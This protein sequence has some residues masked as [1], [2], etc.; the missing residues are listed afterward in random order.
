M[1]I[2]MA[3]RKSGNRLNGKDGNERGSKTAFH[4]RFPHQLL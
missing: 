3:L 2:D 4:V 1:L